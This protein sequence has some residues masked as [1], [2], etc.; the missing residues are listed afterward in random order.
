MVSVIFVDIV[1]ATFVDTLSVVIITSSHTITK[2]PA[3]LYKYL[4]FSQIYYIYTHYN[5]FYTYDTFY[6]HNDI[7]HYSISDLNYMLN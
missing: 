7:Y 2:V 4:A 6:T 1:F 5:H 3:M